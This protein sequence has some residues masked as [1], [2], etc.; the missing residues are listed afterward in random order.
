MVWNLVATTL[1]KR[2]KWRLSERAEWNHGHPVGCNEKS[3]GQF[4]EIL[5]KKME[6][7]NP[8]MRKHQTN[9]IWSAFHKIAGLSSSQVSMSWRFSKGWKAASDWREL[10][11]RIPEAACD[12]E[13][14]HSVWRTWMGQWVKVG[15]SL[16]IRWQW[17][18]N[19]NFLDLTGY[20]E[21]MSCFGRK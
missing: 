2:S 3:Q 18:I 19:A 11:S 20:L 12:S 17:C 15:W 4:W 16:R 10:K 14:D 7:L 5:A 6:T 21:W 9:P 13:L 1:I 8:I